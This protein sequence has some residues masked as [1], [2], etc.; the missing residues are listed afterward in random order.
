M[1]SHP[2]HG[3]LAKCL[4][5][6]AG[7]NVIG[8]LTGGKPQGRQSGQQQPAR[9][10][11]NCRG[12]RAAWP[13]CTEAAGGGTAASAAHTALCAGEAPILQYGGHAVSLLCSPALHCQLHYL[14][15]M[16]VAPAC[17][18]AGSPSQHSTHRPFGAQ[19]VGCVIVPSCWLAE[20][21]SW[22]HAEAAGSTGTAQSDTGAAGTR[23]TAKGARS[24]CTAAEAAACPV[25]KEA[26]AGGGSVGLR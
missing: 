22:L 25:A 2:K 5:L 12:W 16:F 11:A 7:P 24:S 21:T 4:G 8:R 20:A 6:S 19:S 15:G 18:A 26:A 3:N 9:Q 17:A 10:Q 1:L 23:S 14:H 13:D